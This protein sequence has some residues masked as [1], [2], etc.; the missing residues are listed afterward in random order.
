MF[1]KHIL[2]TKQCIVF[3][4]ITNEH[5]KHGLMKYGL[6]LAIC[7][8]IFLAQMPKPTNNVQQLK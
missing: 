3:P 5:V 7:W 2:R 1:G 6:N 8:L 4:L